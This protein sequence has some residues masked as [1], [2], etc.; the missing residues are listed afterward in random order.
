M[1]RPLMVP[2]LPDTSVTT[3]GNDAGL[4]LPNC[5]RLFTPQHTMVSS[6]RT[7]QL[8]LA[9]ADKLSTS[10]SG[11]GMRVIG[12]VVENLKRSIT[13][14]CVGWFVF[15]PSP[16]CPPPLNPQQRTSPAARRAQL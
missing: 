3:S 16:S 1:D 12:I 13:V 4:V 15:D 8:T 6:T 10:A 5:P 2:P 7:A 9:A 11:T 14:V